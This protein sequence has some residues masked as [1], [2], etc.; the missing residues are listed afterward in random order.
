M[1]QKNS[2]KGLEILK[3]Q[4][5]AGGVLSMGPMLALETSWKLVIPLNP[6]GSL[7][8]SDWVYITYVSEYFVP[9]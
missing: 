3:K 8:L 9:S 1:D 7:N 4:Q 5:V 6:Y 2:F